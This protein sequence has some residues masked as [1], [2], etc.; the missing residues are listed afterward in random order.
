MYPPEVDISAPFFLGLTDFFPPRNQQP[1]STRSIND[2][3]C[4]KSIVRQG[5][6][7]LLL[8]RPTMDVFTNLNDSNLYIICF[9]GTGLVDMRSIVESDHTMKGTY[10]KEMLKFYLHIQAYIFYF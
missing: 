7:S 2:I 9:K 6:Q 8:V 3:L 10:Q 1:A 5:I 4:P